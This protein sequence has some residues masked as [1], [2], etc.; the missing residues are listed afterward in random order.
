MSTTHT[1]VDEL[2]EPLGTATDEDLSRFLN[3]LEQRNV[4]LWTENGK[5]KF[6]AAVGTLS[7]ADKTLLR[8]NK[9][10]IIRL[11]SENDARVVPDPEAAFMP[12]GMTEIQQAYA[13]GRNNAFQYGGTACHI[14]LELKYEDL[15]PDRVALIWQ[16]LVARHPMLRA[17][18]SMEGIQQVMPEVP[19]L[20][21]EVH[22]LR[23]DSA[24]DVEAVREDVKASMDHRIYEIG[25]WPLFHIGL[26]RGPEDTVLHFSIEFITADWA[27]IWTVLSEFEQL[28]FE[29]T[30][31]LPALNVTFRDYLKAEEKMR[32]GSH[33]LRDRSWWM[34]RVDSLPSAPE[35]PVLPEVEGGP[36]RFDRLRFALDKPTWDDFCDQAHKAGV[37][38]ATAV[39]TA[40]AAALARWSQKQS[41]CL[42]LSILNRLQLH[43]EIQRVVGDFTTASL[44]QVEQKP[45]D[46]FR[47]LGRK[48]NQQLFDDLDHRLFSGVEVMREL[49]RRFGRERALM[50]YVFTGAIGLID[51]K[52]SDL[53]GQMTD[54]GISQTPQVF[55]DCQAMDTA[56]GLNINLDYRLGVFPEGVVEAVAGAMEQLLKELAAGPQLWERPALRL[57]L[58]TG[59]KA[60]RERVNAVSVELDR[61]LLHEK[62]LAQIQLEPGRLAVADAWREW[63]GASLC[64][65]TDRLM[66]ALRAKGVKHGDRVAIILEKSAWQLAA[67]LAILAAG[68]AY[69]PL[70]YKQGE[71]RNA[72]ILKK[73]EAAAVVTDES[74]SNRLPVTYPFI[75]VDAPGM[76]DGLAEAGD[77]SSLPHLNAPCPDTRPDDIAYII[78]TSGSTGTPK[79]VV[80]QHGAAVNTIEDIDRRFNVGADDR[81]F[82][83]SRL[84]FDLS[85]YDLFGVIS[86]GGA[87]ILPDPAHYRDPVHWMKLMERYRVTI[88]NTVP[89]LMQMLL[90]YRAWREDEQPD[91][92]GRGEAVGSSEVGVPLRL[93]LLSGDWIPVEQ[94]GLL[95]DAFPGVEVIS[96]GGAT[97]GGIWSIFHVCSSNDARTSGMKS[98]PYG[99]PLANQGFLIL[100]GLGQDCPDHVAGELCITGDS[101]A[102]GYY[103]EPELTAAAF[104]EHEGQ[105]MYRTGDYGCYHPNGDIE[106]I[107]RRDRQVK[108]RGHRIELGEI[109][110]VI[111]KRLGVKDAVCVIHS[112]DKEQQLVAV[113]AGTREWTQ[114]E[115]AGELSAWLP[116]YMVPG[117]VIGLE[118][119]PLTA[120][121]KVDQRQIEALIAES[122]KAR[123]TAD[124]PVA[125]M[126]ELEQSIAEVMRKELN[127]AR[128]GPSDDFYDLG[129]NSLVMARAAGVLAKT[130]EK[131]IPFDAFLVGLL[132]HPN[133]ADLAAYARG[134]GAEAGSTED[135]TTETGTK[136]AEASDVS[137]AS[138]AGGSGA[139]AS[140]VSEPGRDAGSG[141]EPG[142]GPVLEWTATGATEGPRAVLFGTGLDQALV[143]ELRA[144]SGLDLLLVGRG[145]AVPAIVEAMDGRVLEDQ[146][147]A[148]VIA[149]FGDLVPALE[150]ASGLLAAGWSMEPVVLLETDEDV[151]I[152]DD[153]TYF[154]DARVG[155]TLS[156][157]E[158]GEEVIEVLREICFGDVEARACH[159]E[160]CRRSFLME[161]VRK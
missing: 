53:I 135:G 20:S 8:T 48:L 152:S 36:A 31:A 74:W 107:G 103:G 17:N 56:H 72:A 38:P 12:F 43:P 35:L 95:W 114:A 25:S 65:A 42:N 2:R 131:K 148:R 123:G 68:A 4:Q 142:P 69:V 83:L 41:F 117:L 77:P 29:Q 93:V 86:Q 108:L 15:D 7:E 11:L 101:L 55:M 96:L 52:E 88:W 129:A 94:P 118:S 30:E 92:G 149:G 45:E 120:N 113:L 87:V 78:F 161:A 139:A 16:R 81:V 141:S 39:M 157:G 147:A 144:A 151:E 27:S 23:S 104:I 124:G 138:V 34:D 145:T 19:E 136:A 54:R 121:G 75:L 160:E 119:I 44:L 73:I 71:E 47:D 33:Y 22:D 50:P 125:P 28:Y 140:A 46:S 9:E 1:S 82:S 70:D 155:L 111:K 156:S 146:R 32:G 122:L 61:H 62:V 159:D 126:D 59:Q 63:T 85:V 158:E 102:L 21:I 40:Y 127:V 115:V 49:Q 18:M 89:A 76:E 91:D 100:D 84:N 130:I 154:G 79:G 132:N 5:I 14:Y 60:V 116:G 97:E 57:P 105:R 137:A 67:A 98:I 58:P 80:M 3:I 64:A 106:F 153:L 99:R 26:T 6:K 128:L 90:I 112:H 51:H 110:A 134:Y 66:G 24:V 13:L 143:D 10:S 37:T 150:L 133:V 109:E